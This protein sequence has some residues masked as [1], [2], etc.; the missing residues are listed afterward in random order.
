MTLKKGRPIRI[1][2][3]MKTLG[4]FLVLQ[5]IFIVLDITSWIPNFKEGGLLERLCN[6]KFI[7]EWFTPYNTPQFNVY[8]AFFAILLL[9]DVLTSAIKGLFSRKKEKIVDTIN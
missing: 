3:W 6:S 7:S 5:L 8:T 4:A 9:L 1:P 2:G